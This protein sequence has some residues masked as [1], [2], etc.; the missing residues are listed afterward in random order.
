[1]HPLYLDKTHSMR[2]DSFMHKRVNITLD[3]KIYNDLVRHAGPRR[4]SEFIEGAIRPLVMDDQRQLEEGYK[5]MARDEE[6]ERDAR[7]WCEGLLVDG[8]D[9]EEENQPRDGKK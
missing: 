7:E 9:D 1:V 6:H 8:I 2:H 5:A 4:I 3:Q